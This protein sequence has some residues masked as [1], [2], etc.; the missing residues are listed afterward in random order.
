MLF[1]A[2]IMQ[3]HHYAKAPFAFRSCLSDKH[4]EAALMLRFNDVAL[5]HGK[6]VPTAIA[7]NCT[8]D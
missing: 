8:I 3:Q 4:G 7:Q 2:T 1:L 6:K 5:H